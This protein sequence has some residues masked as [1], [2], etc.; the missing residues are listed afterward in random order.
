MHFVKLPH[1]PPSLLDPKMPPMAEAPLEM[2]EW[3]GEVAPDV[4]YSHPKT[5]KLITPSPI[6]ME[7][8]HDYGRKS[9]GFLRGGVQ[10]EGVIGEP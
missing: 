2:A 6:I 9:K 10:D 1:L 7:V 4:Y 3:L 8:N 5:S